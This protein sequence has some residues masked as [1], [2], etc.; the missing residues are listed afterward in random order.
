MRPLNI[1]GFCTIA[2]LLG[3]GGPQPKVVGGPPP[4][5]TLPCRGDKVDTGKWPVVVANIKQQKLHFHTDGRCKFTDL[6][7]DQPNNPYPPGF[8]N[9]QPP[10]GGGEM[11]SYDYDG[12]PIPDPGYKFIYENDY[13]QDGNGS[14]VI[15]SFI[16]SY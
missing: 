6:Y 3:C 10:T 7:F 12:T 13:P 14:G 2:L 4:P 11:I 5:P 16:K 1:T 15:K 9:R 8:S